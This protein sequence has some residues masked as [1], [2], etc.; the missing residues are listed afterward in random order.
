MGNTLKCKICLYETT[1]SNLRDKICMDCHRLA[2]QEKL[3]LHFARK[4]QIHKQKLAY[5][6]QYIYTKSFR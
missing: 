5:Q 3:D 1:R 4:H 2:P 6:N